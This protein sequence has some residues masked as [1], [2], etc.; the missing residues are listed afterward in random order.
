ME[1]QQEIISKLIKNPKY[2][3]EWVKFA[4]AIMSQSEFTEYELNK[5]NAAQLE[6]IAASLDSKYLSAIVNPELNATQMHLLSMIA[7]SENATDEIMEKLADPE[8]EYA[9]LNFIAKAIVNGYNMYEQIL[10]FLDFDADQI[11]VICAGME[12]GI[13]YCKYAIKEL[14]AAKMNIARLAMMN[15]LKFDIMPDCKVIIL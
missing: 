6:V 9:K 2:D 11:S 8:I 7:A 14:P 12:E 4:A 10:K 3:S 1:K 15:N 5:Y 13:N